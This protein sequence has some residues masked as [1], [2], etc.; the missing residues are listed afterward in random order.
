M[1]NL[2]ILAVTEAFEI[3]ILIGAHSNGCI[4]EGTALAIGR[5]VIPS[6]IPASLDVTDDS[7][8]LLTRATNVIFAC[9][10]WY[11]Q[12]VLSKAAERVMREKLGPKITPVWVGCARWIEFMTITFIFMGEVC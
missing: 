2:Q 1:P 5:P 6:Y 10:S 8:Y 7:S 9:L 4:L 11:Q 3:K 12:K